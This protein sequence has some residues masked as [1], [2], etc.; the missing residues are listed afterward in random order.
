MR[1]RHRRYRDQARQAPPQRARNDPVAVRTEKWC[2]GCQTRKPLDDF[3]RNRAARDGHS[4]YCRPCHNARGAKS[5]ER[6][7]GARD[8]HLMRRYGITADQFDAMVEAQG[9]VC[10]LCRARKPE[11]V[12]H[13]HLTGAVRGVLCSCCNQGLGNFRDDAATLRLAADYLERTTWQRHTE[14]TGVYR[15]TSPRPAV[16]R[17][18]SSSALQHL[19]SSRGAGPCPP[20]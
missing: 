17:S 10:A 16:R 14:G 20:G 18:P 13:D 7:G 3:T 5:R 6:N 15:L 2:P 12:D 11:H 4:G 1:L 19:I 8:Y 9:G